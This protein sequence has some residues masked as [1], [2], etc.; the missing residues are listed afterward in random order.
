MH[1]PTTH[2][3]EE[4]D[5]YAAADHSLRDSDAY[6]QAKYRLTLRW[7]AGLPRGLRLANIGCGGGHFNTMA[8]EAGFQ[9]TGYEP[10]PQAYAL[11]LRAPRAGECTV[12]NAGLEAI[13]G[14]GVAD[15]IVMHDVL[16]H[17]ADEEGAVR[18]LRRLVAADGRVVLSVP[19]MP[20]LFGY[21]DEMLGHERRYTRR[22]LRRALEP[23]FRIERLRAYGFA[24]IPVTAYYS[25]WRR[26]PYP[27]A[28]GTGDGVV[29]RAMRA[30]CAIEGRV[31][32]PIG[33]SLI[34]AARPL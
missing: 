14:T 23:C 29:G 22:T 6:A 17:I 25:R 18:H 27:V 19:S 3:A 15:V 9:V 12:V 5:A 30:V 21:H 20:S 7:L 26:K 2:G 13:D 32:S 33:T 10:D 24:L 28:E 16:E 4:P 34:C 8:V 1:E 11:A 31:P